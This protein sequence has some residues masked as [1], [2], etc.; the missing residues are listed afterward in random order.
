M[1]VS[2]APGCAAWDITECLTM[3]VSVARLLNLPNGMARRPCCRNLTVMLTERLMRQNAS[4]KSVSGKVPPQITVPCHHSAFTSSGGSKSDSF[5]STQA[6]TEN[7]YLRDVVGPKIHVATSHR[8]PAS[9]F[10]AVGSP[11]PSLWTSHSGE[12]GRIVVGVLCLARLP[13]TP[14]QSKMP[15]GCRQP[16]TPPMFVRLGVVFLTSP[17]LFSTVHRSPVPT[18][19]R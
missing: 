6:D 12:V 7:G 1:P 8:P 11:S 16:E 10:P 9:L 4:D 13:T 15:P 18:V 3:H 19:I 17:Q 5:A 2:R 14:Y